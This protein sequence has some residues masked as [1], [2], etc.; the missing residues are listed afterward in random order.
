MKQLTIRQT[1]RFLGMWLGMGVVI[2]LA[3]EDRGGD[4]GVAEPD[5]NRDVEAMLEI[6]LSEEAK[7][8]P[9]EV[10]AAPAAPALPRV[11]LIGDSIAGGYLGGV[12]TQLRHVAHV[13]R[14][15]SGGTTINGLQ[16][17][18]AILGDSG[19]DVIHFNWG[20]HDMTWQRRMK[21][22]E[23]GIEAYA[24]RLERLVERLKQTDA[25]LIWATTTPWPEE[26][27]AYYESRFGEKLVY[28]PAEEK[29]WMEAALAVM[30]NHEIPVNDLYALLKPALDQYQRPDDVHF[31]REGSQAMARR[32]ADVVRSSLPPRTE[33]A[34]R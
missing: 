20:L 10:P 23:L 28:S 9:D 30:R 2:A 14:G 5:Y 21:P 3:G 33:N 24:A 32:I 19:W 31:N 8:L 15:N 22:D 34:P 1:L 27:Y 6:G 25:R 7:G 11:L 18:D 29:Q 17:I 26:N 4:G 13:E 16:N 12:K